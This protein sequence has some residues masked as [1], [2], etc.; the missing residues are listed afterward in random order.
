M[1][2]PLL[3]PNDPKFQQ[4]EIRDNEGKNRFAEAADKHSSAQETTD[5]YAVAPGD[6]PR[7]FVPQYEVQQRSRA[8]LLLI[9]GGLGWAAALIGGISLTGI[10]AIGWLAPLLGIFPA[11]GA[12]FLAHEEIRA[13][14]SGAIAPQALSPTRHSY[15]L[16]VTGLLACLAIV[17][18]MIYREMNVLPAL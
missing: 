7:P 12:W 3:R 9:L 1:S 2:N 14:R 10:F 6:E 11:G 8:N 17:A 16:G 5:I 4:P 13:I 15:W 18:A